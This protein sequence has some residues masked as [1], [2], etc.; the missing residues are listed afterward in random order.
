M[1]PRPIADRV[2]W[3][4]AI[5]WDRRLFDELIPLPDGT[6]YNAYLVQG[7]EKTALIDTV[8]P[9]QSG[10][11]FARLEAAGVQRIDVVV[12]NHAE[13]DHSGT[14][15]AVLARYP[16]A[17]VLTSEKGR[18]MLLDLLDLPPERVRVV[19]DG[20]CYSLGDLTLQF[21]AFP[22][23]HWPETMLTW[24]PE[25][26][27]LFSCD[28][29]GSHL[30]TADVLAPPSEAEVWLAAKRYY[31]EIMMPFRSIIAKN[32]EKVRALNAA[33]IA[34]S[35]GP[36]YALPERI[37]QAY[38]EWMAPVPQNL[39]VV[40][41]ISMHDSTRRLVEHFV[42]ACVARG[43]GV[44]QVNLGEPDIGKLAMLLVDA[45]TIVLGT[46]TVIAGP[47]PKVAYAAYLANLLR[48]K[49]RFLG[50]VG[51]YG[52]G[53]KA[54]EQLAALLPNVKAELLKPVLCKGLPKPADLAALD[55]LAAGIA[56]RHRAL[57]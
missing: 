42:D 37:L 14:L 25:R 15:P 43:V 17:V 47:H 46:P 53:G 51:S 56:E 39:A 2:Q 35:H 50:V 33:L 54:A 20:E 49:A 52:W 31:A 36:V 10:A 38:D 1:K 12:A 24:L 57:N 4:G 13:Q 55:E 3:V 28:L 7:S 45:A 5:D 34:P 22:W 41:Y 44:Q 30:A 27:V 16:E 32:I 48:P 11:L 18:P 21:I 40:A 9:P 8:D 19:G 6:S 26:R 29:F 23:V